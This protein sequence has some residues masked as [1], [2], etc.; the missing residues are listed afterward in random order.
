MFGA[1]TITPSRFHAPPRGV[2]ASQRVSAGPPVTA[3]FLSLPCAKKPRCASSGDQNG[4]SASSVP[5][6][7]RASSES[8][9]RIQRRFA[10]P[11]VLVKT[12]RRPLGESAKFAVCG[13]ETLKRPD[14][15][16]GADSRQCRT[17]GTASAVATST[18]R[19][20]TA[21]GQP[22]AWRRRFGRNRRRRSVRLERT[23]E[24]ETHVAHRLRPLT[25]VLAQA[26][27][28]DAPDP[29][30][31]LG[32]ERG[33]VRLESGNRTQHVDDV[34]AVERPFRGEHLVAA[35]SRTTRCRPAC[36]RPGRGPAPATCRPPYRGSSPSASALDLLG[37]RASVEGHGG[38]GDRRRL[39]DV[40]PLVPPEPAP[41]RARSP[42]PSP[43]RRAGL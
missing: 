22:C 1:K 34:V 19:P 33:E 35:R 36:R 11:S 15:C 37:A 21:Q 4:R 39:H 23:V 41:W 2:G 12:S 20:K 42:A 14:S 16:V 27:L 7:S 18:A 32:R 8:S 43:C 28:Q 5:R 6:I 30:R 40:R 13:S 9:G 10:P 25:R 26:E 29:W 3:T 31:H 17:A 38:R 24:C